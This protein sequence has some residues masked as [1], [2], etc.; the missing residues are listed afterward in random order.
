M[1]V[2]RK[3][4]VVIAS[5]SPKCW[6]T[7]TRT[8]VVLGEQLEEFEAREIE[9]VV[10]AAAHQVGVDT[11]L[12]CP[13]HPPDA[14]SGRKANVTSDSSLTEESNGM[15]VNSISIPIRS[16]SGDTSTRRDSTLTSPGSSM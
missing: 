10:L 8:C 4:H 6:A 1:Y 2:T 7:W 9:V 13:P 12:H 15:M 3:S 14:S 5:T 16:C 11:S